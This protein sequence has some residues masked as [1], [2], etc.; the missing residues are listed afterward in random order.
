MA[1]QTQD[2]EPEEVMDQSVEEEESENEEEETYIETLTREVASEHRDSIAEFTEDPETP[3]ELSKNDSI[4]KFLV[5]K[6]RDKLL[7][8]FESQIQWVEDDDLAAMMKKWRR[9]TAIDEDVDVSVAMKRI[10][11]D[12]IVINEVVEKHLEELME[13]QEAEDEE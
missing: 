5:Q 7:E 10:I 11:K 2:S 4:R 13:T 6:V 8:S 1:S 9:V 12:N 3:E